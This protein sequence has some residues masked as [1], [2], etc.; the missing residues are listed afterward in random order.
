MGPMVFM[1]Q[2]VQR[3]F[4]WN[5]STYSNYTTIGGVINVTTMFLLPPL[6]VKV[7]VPLLADELNFTNTLHNFR[8]SKCRI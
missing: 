4:N 1:F 3:V 2:Y 6:L 8:F 5:S 7:N